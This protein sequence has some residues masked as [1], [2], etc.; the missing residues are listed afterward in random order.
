MSLESC[1]VL[2]VGG[3]PAG[4][5]CARALRR[6]GRDV[7]VLDKAPFPRVKPCA[8]WITP[9]VVA[10]LEL[11]VAAYRASGRVF[12]PITGFRLGVMGGRSTRSTYDEPVSYGIRRAEFDHYLLDRSGAR[13]RL[14][15]LLR[16]LRR[17]G[18][19]W[20]VNE[21][22]RTPLVVG[23]GGY[24]C[25]VARHLGARPGA[26]EVAVTAQEF[27]VALDD[28]Q[29]AACPVD[30]EVPELCFCRDLKG[31]GWCF[32][33]GPVL[34]VGLGRLDPDRLPEHVAAFH[35]DLRRRGRLP[36][37]LEAKSR[38]HAYV[39]YEYTR[40]PLLA[41]GLLLIGDAAGLAYV[42]SGEGIRPAVES[43]L[44][45]A[46]TILAAEGRADRVALA[47]YAAQ[48]RA[49]FG[50]PSA[51]GPWIDRLPAALVGF[52]GRR[53]LASPWFNRRVVMEQWFLHAHEPPLAL[54]HGQQ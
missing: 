41:D 25:P 3:G 44:M 31:Y 5:T 15:E 17:D 19:G 30:P 53:L 10:E 16:A 22:I 42:Q 49:R 4:S 24:F 52:L 32:R 46:R 2:I 11:D 29:A 1:D 14:G 36:D 43:A 40:R 26:G 21:A 33:K 39:L 12:Q 20:V 34:N 35:D 47:S 38:G 23:A 8:G 9:A 37:G 51:R 54:A 45:A 48:V 13:L 6:A 28:R 27:E 7:V 18:G 50:M